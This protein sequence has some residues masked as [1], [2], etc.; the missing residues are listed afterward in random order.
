M[1]GSWTLR[2]VGTAVFTAFA[3]LSLAA[4]DGSTTTTSTSSSG[5][6]GNGGSGGSGGGGTSA[7]NGER[8]AE[9]YCDQLFDCCN[10]VDLVERFGTASNVVDYA[11]CRILYRTI[12]E[13]GIEPVLE[14]GVKAGRVEFSQANF[15]TCMKSVGEL[16]CADLTNVSAVCEDVFTPKVAPGQTC[17]SDIE[18]I[19]GDCEIP[20]DATSGTCIA[21]PAP[22]ALGGA[23]TNND[24]CDKGLYC[25]ASKCDTK[26]PDG[27]DCNNNDHCASGACVGE[28]NGMMGKCATICQGGGPGPGDV[29]KTLETIGGEFVVAECNKFFDCCVGAELDTVLFPGMRTEAQCLNLF[30]IFLGIALVDLHNSS[31]QG[32]VAVDPAALDMCLQDFAGQ[33]CPE[34]AKSASFECLDAIKGLVADGSSCTDDN[35][36]TSNYCNESMPNQGICATLPGVGA[37][38]TSDC[39]AGLYCDG[40][41]CVMQKALGAMCAGTRECAEGRCFGPSGMMTCTLVCDGI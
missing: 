13:G 22:V 20:K 8:Y 2:F 16:S 19:N 7:T 26:R 23:C 40:G 10:T 41:M 9:A 31:V 14:E 17:F 30:G 21:K 18:C 34:F 37:P 38:C 24:E 12:W 6:A 5:G 11:G 33:T 35:Q 1:N 4:C 29:D 25:N 32:K 28:V 3:G 15:D 27:Q 36:C 39:A